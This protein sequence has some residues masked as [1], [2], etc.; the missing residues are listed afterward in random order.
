MY[1]CDESRSRNIIHVVME[2]SHKILYIDNYA[3]MHACDYEVDSFYNVIGLL[4]TW[5]QM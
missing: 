3:R 2:F 4:C 1:T 5:Y